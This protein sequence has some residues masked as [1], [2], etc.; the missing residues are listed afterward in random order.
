M[1]ELIKS[2]NTIYSFRHAGIF[3]SQF[4]K[5][6]QL[7][8]EFEVVA[9]FLGK[10][11]R[12]L[13]DLAVSVVVILL[14]K[15]IFLEPPEPLMRILT[16][17]GTPNPFECSSFKSDLRFLQI[18]NI[19][20]VD[21][22]RRKKMSSRPITLELKEHVVDAVIA[23]NKT[24]LVFPKVIDDKSHNITTRQVLWKINLFLHEILFSMF[25]DELF[26]AIFNYCENYMNCVLISSIL[27]SKLSSINKAALIVVINEYIRNDNA[28]QYINTASFILFGIEDDS[29]EYYFE[30]SHIQELFRE[31]WLLP[32]EGGYGVGKANK[33]RL[34]NRTLSLINLNVLMYQ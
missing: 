21:Y 6:G 1:N 13:S 20:S 9:K 17:I 8:H 11:G 5:T 28:E 18:N 25:N 4:Y 16:M 24:D 34:S 10:S 12:K 30:D 27:N 3:K 26:E 31:N 29:F 33:V 7:T 14:A 32:V 15:K 2:C 19:I 23:Y 22:G